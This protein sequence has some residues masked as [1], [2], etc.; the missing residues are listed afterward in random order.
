MSETTWEE[1]AEA[2]ATFVERWEIFTRMADRL[3]DLAPDPEHLGAVIDVAGG[4][5]LVT[6]RALERDP[7]ALVHVVEP[8]A[9]MLRHVRERLGERLAGSAQLSCEE[10]DSYPHTA[11]LIL[12]SAAFHL[13]DAERAL[14]AVASR[15]EPGGTFVF[16]LWWHGWEPTASPEP[17]PRWREALEAAARSADVEL[18]LPEATPRRVL[19][20]TTLEGACAASDLELVHE[21]RDEDSLSETFWI[22]FAAMSPSF[23]REV[24][25]PT[26]TRLLERAL[27]RCTGEVGVKT[28]RIVLRRR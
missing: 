24:E 17:E 6:R 25:E 18:D 1:R 9:S 8:A 27:E 3:I 22:E 10:L 19:T 21:V 15:L 5:G 13:I 28:T 14:P 23:L 2:Y 4:T 11:N 26:R 7:E 16:N 12:C 20:P